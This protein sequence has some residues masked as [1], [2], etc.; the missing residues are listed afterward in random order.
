[1]STA[2]T[3][4]E[5]WDSISLPFKFTTLTTRFKCAWIKFSPTFSTLKAIPNKFIE[6]EAQSL[7]CL[8]FSLSLWISLFHS[9]YDKTHV[10]SSTASVTGSTAGNNRRRRASEDTRLGAGQFIWC[11]WWR[12]WKYYSKYQCRRNYNESTGGSP[13]SFSGASEETACSS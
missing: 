12:K 7:H 6:F 9:E 11:S 13:R 8:H 2:L 5:N 1:M 3:A 10:P 4:N